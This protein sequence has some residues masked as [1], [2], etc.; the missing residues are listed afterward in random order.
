MN[1]REAL[2]GL[3]ATSLALSDAIQF[4]LR[5]VDA[6]T[7]DD[8]SAINGYADLV[9]DSLIATG[10]VG[11]WEPGAGIAVGRDVSQAELGELLGS[12]R[13]G[14]LPAE[15]VLPR[16]ELVQQWAEILP[17]ADPSAPSIEPLEET[18]PQ[19]RQLVRAQA[20]AQDLGQ[21]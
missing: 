11:M 10:H 13:I 19:D 2:R 3:Q 15:L 7:A 16:L 14:P 4:I 9:L 17:M 18:E 21:C 1:I 12:G 20:F 5:R 6:P 8:A